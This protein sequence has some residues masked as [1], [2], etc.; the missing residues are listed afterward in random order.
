MTSETVTRYVLGKKPGDF[1]DVF[2]DFVREAVVIR[3]GD[4]II[5]EPSAS[6]VV[7]V[8]MRP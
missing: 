3:G 5:V 1:V 2:Y 4:A 8:R 6:N 7:Y